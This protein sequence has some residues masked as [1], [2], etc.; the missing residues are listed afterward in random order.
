[1]NIIKKQNQN[2]IQLL[3]ITAQEIIDNAE[4]II[5]VDDND[6]LNIKLNI[7]IS[8]ASYPMISVS[9]TYTSAKTCIEWY[10]QNEF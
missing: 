5:N 6:I 8:P 9:K 3:K 4:K 7:S 10:K 2:M 1:M